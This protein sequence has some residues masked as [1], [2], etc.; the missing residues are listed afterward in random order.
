M[1][2]VL[3]RALVVSALVL[4]GLPV[5]FLLVQSASLLDTE[6]VSVLASGATWLSALRTVLFGVV[7]ATVCVALALPLAWLTHCTDLPGRRFFQIAL[8]LPLA[9][10]SYVSAYV[11]MAALGH[12]G[13][14]H[15]FLE[16]L[17][18]E[19][20]PDVRGG[21]GATL[22]LLWSYPFALLV[23]QAAL[24]R[25]DPRLWE[26][27]RSL[28]A[29][30]WQ[31]FRKVVLPTLRP[32]LGAGFLLVALYAVSDFGAVSL[33]RF[34][35]LSFVIYQRHDSILETYQQEAVFLSLLLVLIAVAFV[36]ALELTRGKVAASLSSQSAHRPWPVVRLG[37]FR[38]PATIFCISV[39]TIGVGLPIIIVSWWLG[40]GLYL[41]HDIAIPWRA[42][43]ISAGLAVGAAL[44]AVSAAILPALLGRFGRSADATTVRIA[45][46]MGYALPGIAVG[47]ALVSMVTANAF[48]L[49]QTVTL[50]VAAYVIR[51]LPLAL[52]SL[53]ES[54]LAQNR[55][56]YDAARSLGHSPAASIARVVVPLS[57]PAIWA[58]L[59]AV[60][61]AVIKELPV[62]L[63][64]APIEVALP[65]V[66]PV[67]F[68]T[69]A[70]QIWSLTV[71]EFLSQVAPVVLI[72]LALATAGLLLRPDT[73]KLRR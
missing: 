27:A 34:K 10:P 62:T 61:I 60:L 1:T 47:L 49:Y 67:R 39:V 7:V 20:M 22:A 70:T 69:L 52:H 72:L 29:S 44:I 23:V 50:L 17:G 15:F 58:G 48:A 9:V 30:P 64:L 55:R 45:A 56:I 4:V 21:V 43:G 33:L 3:T 8:I 54:L 28:G 11:V 35:T 12:G 16:P 65:G 24:A 71:D 63:L 6:A 25:M 36:V 41:G 14:L 18:V 46:L 37:R 5:L 13:W 42:T 73:T 40:R 59:L 32:A 66:E 2:T 31:A 68:E 57:A 38:A 53:S 51:F 26:A 19:T